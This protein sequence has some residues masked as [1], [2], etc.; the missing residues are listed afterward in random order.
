MQLT[1]SSKQRQ[2]GIAL[3]EALIAILII[4]L[5][6]LGVMGVQMRTLS[7]TQTGVRRAQAIRL[8]EDFSERLKVNPNSMHNIDS[9]AASWGDKPTSSKNCLTTTCNNSEFAKFEIAQWKASVSQLLPGG[10]A[11]V[12]VPEAKG[13]RDNRRELGVMISWRENEGSDKADFLKGLK[14]TIFDAS[15]VSCEKNKTCHLQFISLNGRCAPYRVK[16]SDPLFF[17]S[18]S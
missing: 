14:D 12:F 1:Y 15:T 9:Y 11:T 5:G 10:N 17:C 6:I 7:D 3:I 2:Q 8:I 4:A 13:S 18:S 16:E